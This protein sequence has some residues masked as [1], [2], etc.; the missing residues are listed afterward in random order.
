MKQPQG[1]TNCQITKRKQEIEFERAWIRH[2]VFEK[3]DIFWYQVSLLRGRAALAKSLS[4]HGAGRIN[5]RS[6][7]NSQNFLAHGEKF[8]LR[9]RK[10]HHLASLFVFRY[11][12]HLKNQMSKPRC[13]PLNEVL[14]QDLSISSLATENGK[15]RELL[16]GAV[17][18]K[19][20]LVVRSND[21]VAADSLVGPISVPGWCSLVVSCCFLL[22]FCASESYLH[23][24]NRAVGELSETKSGSNE[25]CRTRRSNY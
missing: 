21:Q 6:T 12:N 24:H 7:L 14:W 18:G 1:K 3:K 20:L 16:A 8:F 23:L 17:N 11:N 22:Y 19:V 13:P 10:R 25:L 5:P 15:C 2:K 9:I 4:V